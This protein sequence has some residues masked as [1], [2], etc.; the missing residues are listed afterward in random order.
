MI[1]KFEGLKTKAYLCP[2]GVLTIGYGHTHGVITGDVCTAEQAEVWLKEDCLVA[3]LTLSADVN[4]SLSQNQFDALVSF[5]FNL[6]SGN[7]IKSTLLQKL[8]A[9]D[10]AGAADEF[11][12]WVNA[13]GRKL[14]GL[15]KRRAAEKMLFLS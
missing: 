7:F 13:G 9:R 6:G 2:A 15:V 5:I 4:V 12:K 3:E 11:G 1:K 14:P 8:N 10:Y